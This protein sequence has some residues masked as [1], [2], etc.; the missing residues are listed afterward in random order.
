MY[1][2]HNL[3]KIFNRSILTGVLTIGIC[4][5]S[6]T[7]KKLKVL[8]EEN[9][10]F[11]NDVPV[12]SGHGGEVSKSD[13]DANKI[14][15]PQTKGSF[16]VIGDDYSIGVMSSTYL[17]RDHLAVFDDYFAISDYLN[18]L[19]LGQN[20]L[21]LSDSTPADER[22]KLYGYNPFTS[23]NMISFLTLKKFNP[24][25]SQNLGRRG[26]SLSR[27]D[28]TIL[29]QINLLKPDHKLVFVQIG[30]QD[31]CSDSLS[32]S[33]FQGNYSKMIADILKKIPKLKKIV[34][35]P[36]FPVF[37]L[38]DLSDR[39]I[40]D[41]EEISPLEKFISEVAF[42]GDKKNMSCSQIHK[43]QCPKLVVQTRENNWKMWNA[44]N[45]DISK[46]I[47][48]VKNSKNSPELIFLS[49]IFNGLDL[50]SD[51]M[52]L[53]CLHPG[54]KVNEKIANVLFNKIS[55]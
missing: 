39:K 17:N 55:D 2:S 3:K 53:D 9:Q 31:F 45:E 46:S 4:T 51:Q 47:V 52:S 49:E 37:R 5:V 16:A 25:L 42:K 50:G 23:T 7:F 12:E 19:I 32:P 15:P 48:N 14:S 13:G 40:F 26:A 20:P 30:T 1:T 8:K 22:F 21:L 27:Y 29:S 54:K 36:P 34:L 38:A 18:T 43:I 6:C 44:M 28:Q 24:Q 41:Y 10:N 11:S 35:I 33:E